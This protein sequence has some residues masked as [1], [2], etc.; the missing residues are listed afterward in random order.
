MLARNATALALVVSHGEQEQLAGNELV[1][2][3]DGFLLGGVEQV[4]EVAAHLDLVGALHLRQPLDG[5]VQRGLQAADVHAGARQ[6]RAR[7]AIVLRQQ[8]AQQVHRFDVLVVMPQRQALRISKRLL[9]PGGEFIESHSDPSLSRK[10]CPVA[11]GG[12]ARTRYFGKIG[13]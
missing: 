8:R 12:P 9:E 10:V 4:V 7:G 3:L 11:R 2:A 5:G 6:Q 13:L 1:I